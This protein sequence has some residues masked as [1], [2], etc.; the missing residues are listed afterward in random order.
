MIKRKKYT[1]TLSEEGIEALTKCSEI[2]RRSKSSTIEEAL[3][4]LMKEIEDANKN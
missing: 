4:K 1:F 3:F 2:L